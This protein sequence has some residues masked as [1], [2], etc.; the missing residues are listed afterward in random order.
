MKKTP[1]TNKM[2]AL[3]LDKSSLYPQ[4]LDFSAL[5]EVASWQWFDNANPG[6]IQPGLEGAEILVTNKVLISSDVVDLCQQ[7][8]LICVAAT[9]V[10]NVDL[11]AAKKRGITVC[12]VRAYATSSVVQHVFS[13][14]L[15]LNRKLFSYKSSAVNGDWSRSDFFCY[16]G[17]PISELAGKTLGIV[18]YGELGQA[19]AKVARCFGMKVLIARSHNAGV[20]DLND[21]RV[22]LGVLFSTSDVVSLHCPLTEANHHVIGADEFDAMKSD[23]ILINTA[24]GG[25]VDEAALLHAL[26]NSQIGGA[27]LDVLEEEP[28]SVNNALINYQVDKLIITPHIAWAGRESRQ[29]LVDG[30]AENIRAYKQG[31]PVNIV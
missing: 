16:F 28:P 22:D 14:M 12:N 6:D 5:Q 11:A 24:R 3:F 1:D 25:L 13:L 29:R 30:M 27:A 8:K 4:D 18:G 7:L 9:G 19:V 10:N 26:E 21:A 2:R 31:R 23:A 17:Q 15:A 20:A